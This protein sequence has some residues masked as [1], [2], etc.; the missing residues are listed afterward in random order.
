MQINKLFIN[1][2]TTISKH[3]HC[4][5]P[6]KKSFCQHDRVVQNWIF[7]SCSSWHCKGMFPFTNQFPFFQL[8]L[9]SKFFSLVR[10]AV[11]PL[12]DCL[13][14]FFLFVLVTDWT[15][16]EPFSLRMSWSSSVVKSISSSSTGV[17]QQLSG[18]V[19]PDA[20]LTYQLLLFHVL[21]ELTIVGIC[22]II[23]HLLQH[24][25]YFHGIRTTLLTLEETHTYYNVYLIPKRDH[26]FFIGVIF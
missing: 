25:S 5:S 16:Q 15:G 8:W 26:F 13:L 6:S 14:F 24:N 11:H 12:S 21:L 1:E 22:N 17:I 19:D 18:P 23:M 9:H 10:F 4:F 2:N 3:L 7:G 20:L